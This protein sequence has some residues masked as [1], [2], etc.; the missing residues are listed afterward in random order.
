LV[1]EGQFFSPSAE[2]ARLHIR[3]AVEH[4][5]QYEPA[6]G[7]AALERLV[8]EI[9]SDYFPVKKQ[10]ALTILEKGPLRR[11][12][13][14]LL[15]N[16][17]VLLIKNLVKGHHDYKQ[18]MRYQ[19]AFKGVRDM[20]P[21]ACKSIL[22]GELDKQL[23]P[24][25]A[26]GKL[27]DVFRFVMNEAALWDYLNDDTQVRLR[28]Y[29]ENIPSDCFDSLESAFGIEVL[30]EG[31]MKRIARATI[32]DLEWSFWIVLPQPVADRIIDQYGRAKNFDDA[33]AWGK[34]IKGQ[35]VEFSA[36]DIL[37]IIVSAAKNEQILGSFELPAVIH[38]LKQ[39]KAIPEDQFNTMLAANGLEKFITKAR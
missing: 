1:S 32:E 2:L 25:V 38:S 30:K 33:N 5:L 17:V 37:K 10:D 26:A 35:S 28:T 23:S 27:G 12:R 24:L 16:F 9:E 15:R 34:I 31:A 20:H 39:S 14:S 19:A 6:Q 11:A 3:S 4:L 22:E 21:V 18:V 13:S 7:K 8:R 36:Q 29:V